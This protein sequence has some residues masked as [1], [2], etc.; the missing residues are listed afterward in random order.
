MSLILVFILNTLA[1][2]FPVTHQGYF[3]FR[4][5]KSPIIFRISVYLTMTNP[6]ATEG[7]VRV[8]VVS[9]HHKTSVR[10]TSPLVTNSTY[11]HTNGDRT[12]CGRSPSVERF[13]F[14]N[15]C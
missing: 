9:S 5:I 4:R 15:F 8:P 2:F 3:F 14:S 6:H 10:K 11:V 1:V 12:V 7:Y 13:V